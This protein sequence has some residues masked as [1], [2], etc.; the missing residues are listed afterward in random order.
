VR[1]ADFGDTRINLMGLGDLSGLMSEA[2]GLR[3][4]TDFLKNLINYDKE[5]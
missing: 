4:G 1:T 3:K 2:Y 5:F